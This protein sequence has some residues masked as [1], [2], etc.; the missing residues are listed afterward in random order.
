[1]SNTVLFVCEHGGAKSV[2]AATYFNHLATHHGLA[3]RALARG[4]SPDAEVPRAV[5]EGLARAGLAPCIITPVALAQE[6]LVNAGRVITFDQ[7]QITTRVS[8]RERVIAWN[9][10]P[11]VSAD[12][13]IARDAIVARVRILVDALYA[14][15][16]AANDSA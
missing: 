10:L 11:A 14:S 7:P 13:D 6:D 5:V 4:V 9:D 16:S 2:L 15:R 8:Q 12:F 3:M 1:M